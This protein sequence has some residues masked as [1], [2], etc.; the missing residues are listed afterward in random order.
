MKD[1]MSREISKLATTKVCVNLP[2]LS[3]RR[4]KY[5]KLKNF[6]SRKEEKTQKE[7]KRNVRW[8]AVK[9]FSVAHHNLFMYFDINFPT[10]TNKQRLSKEKIL[11][12]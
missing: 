11:K 5:L 3:N 6:N 7:R 8:L 10:C 12:F 4:Y 2:S 9:N 1:D